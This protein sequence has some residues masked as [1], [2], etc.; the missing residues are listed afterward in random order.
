MTMD[1]SKTKEEVTWI[2]KKAYKFFLRDNKIWWHS[3]KRVV[4]VVED[5]SVLIS[6]FHESS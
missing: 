6:K 3:K 1:V 2:R 4:M 5:Q